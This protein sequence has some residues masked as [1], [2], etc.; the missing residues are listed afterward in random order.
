[1]FYLIG[2][3]INVRRICEFPD[4]FVSDLVVRRG[5]LL[6]NFF[7]HFHRKMTKTLSYFFRFSSLTETLLVTG[8]IIAT[9]DID[10]NE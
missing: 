4:Q 1:M 2:Q 5:S 7:A 8:S 9:L 6:F 10:K 3:R